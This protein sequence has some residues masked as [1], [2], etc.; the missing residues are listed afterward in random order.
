[1]SLLSDAAAMGGIVMFTTGHRHDEFVGTT[2]A[3][4][5]TAFEA[6]ILPV[7]WRRMVSYP[8]R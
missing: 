3:A 7:D 5:V 8:S 1:M 4:H 6:G 2:T